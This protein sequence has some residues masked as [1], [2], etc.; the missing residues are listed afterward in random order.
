METHPEA[1][2]STPT[3]I[4]D[5]VNSKGMNNSGPRSC[6]LPHLVLSCALAPWIL[7]SVAGFL[8]ALVSPQKVS[9][10]RAVS[11]RLGALSRKETKVG[12]ALRAGQAGILR[13]EGPASLSPEPGTHKPL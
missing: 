9:Q 5:P 11:S 4:E 10:P 7:S 12:A 8:S 1:L 2:L 13:G 6:S 3:V